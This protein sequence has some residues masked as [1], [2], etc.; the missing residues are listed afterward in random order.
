V[1]ACTAPVIAEVMAGSFLIRDASPIRV[2]LI[3]LPTTKSFTNFK[4]NA[5]MSNALMPDVHI[6]CLFAISKVLKTIHKLIEADRLEVTMTHRR[7]GASWRGLMLLSTDLF[8]LRQKCFTFNAACRSRFYIEFFK[9]MNDI[10]GT[11]I[12][13]QYINGT[14]LLNG[15]VTI[16]QFTVSD[17]LSGIDDNDSTFYGRTYCIPSSDVSMFFRYKRISSK[18][19]SNILFMNGLHKWLFEAWK[20]PHGCLVQRGWRDLTCLD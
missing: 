10:R 18:I 2:E 4:R 12:D 19:K 5:H 6:S 20:P 11:P 14:F 7:R 8:Y 1:S 3:E 9:F 15:S 17:S 13:I 16:R